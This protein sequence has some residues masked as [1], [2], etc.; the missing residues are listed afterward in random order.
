MPSSYDTLVKKIESGEDVTA[1]ADAFT[2]EQLM[3]LARSAYA[4]DVTLSVLNGPQSMEDA[5]AVRRA[6]RGHVVY[7]RRAA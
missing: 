7:S 1:D 3:M 6:G 4:N 5:I 2:V